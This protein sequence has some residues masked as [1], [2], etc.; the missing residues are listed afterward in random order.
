MW[1]MTEDKLVYV[2][3]HEVDEGLGIPRRVVAIC[4][5]ELLGK[6]FKTSKVN[7]VVNEDFFGG[8]ESTVDEAV[9]Y[10]RQAYT[11]MIV[12]KN[13]VSKAVSEGIIHPESVMKVRGVPYAQLVRM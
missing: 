12:G 5:K 1:V 10:L 9:I 11:A 4:D 13:I 8:F 2:K 6:T 7:L 3:V